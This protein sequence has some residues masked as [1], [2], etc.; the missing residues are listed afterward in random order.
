MT[1]RPA[2]R[3]DASAIARLGMDFIGRLRLD[4]RPPVERVAASVGAVLNDRNGC[5]IVDEVDG[6][7]VGFLLGMAVPIWF[8]VLDWS[9]IE[10][11][12][13]I[14]AQHRG[15]RAAM[16]MVRMFEQWAK[17][18]GVRRVVLS[19]IEFIDQAQPAGALIERLGY[20]LHER[21]FVKVI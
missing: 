3:A 14:D 4:A 5:G 10:L 15:G 9:A 19:D 21:A 2:T 17:D 18:M 12:W 16:G 1:L 6:Q 20:T 13:W 11:A 7:I 8:D